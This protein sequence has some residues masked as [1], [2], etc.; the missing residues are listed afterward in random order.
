M[1]AGDGD[2]D[3]GQ[4]DPSATAF[5]GGLTD[6]AVRSGQSS[7]FRLSPQICKLRPAREKKG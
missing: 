1:S 4:V 6:R 2:D 5:E 3:R 7:L